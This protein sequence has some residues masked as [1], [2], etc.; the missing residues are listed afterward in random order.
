MGTL[1]DKGAELERV[2]KILADSGQT[3]PNYAA[4]A[5]WWESAKEF[6]AVDAQP[7][8]DAGIYGGKQALKL[9]AYVPAT[10]AVCYLLL[11]L[12]FKAKGGYKAVHVSEEEPD[13]TPM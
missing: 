4:Q 12:Y 9:T 11:I 10:M 1:E 13:A 5:A 8:K 2:G 7:V 6:E 3:D